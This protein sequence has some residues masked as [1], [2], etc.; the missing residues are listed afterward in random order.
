[1]TAPSNAHASLHG[2]LIARGGGKENT[3]RQVPVVGSRREGRLARAALAA[4]ALRY[5]KCISAALRTVSAAV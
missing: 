4:R 5:I 2:I 1:M 3:G